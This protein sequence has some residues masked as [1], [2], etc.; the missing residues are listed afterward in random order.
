MQISNIIWPLSKVFAVLLSGFAALWVI[1]KTRASLEMRQGPGPL[2]LFANLLKLVQKGTST[3]NTQSRLFGLCLIAALAGIVYLSAFLTDLD[4]FTTIYI[5]VSIRFF[6]ILAA[7]VQAA[8]FGA[9]GASRE[10]T[11][12][13][14][15]EPALI[16]SLVALSLSVGSIDMHAIIFSSGPTSVAAGIALYLVALVDLSRMPIDD[17]STHLELTM[18]HESMIIECSGRNLAMAE[19]TYAIR[20]GLLFCLI[21]VLF[22][23][24]LCL[25]CFKSAGTF[26]FAI[27]VVAFFILLC[28]T[29]GMIEALWIKMDWRKNPHFIA[30]ALTMS[31]IAILSVLGGH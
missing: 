13:I 20:T 28:L 2:Q 14:L 9:F 26:A 7:L 8:P 17:P 18:V 15:C 31:F 10:L 19:S 16:L 1:R 22:A 12:S 5:L 27:I 21:S 4:I 29:T 24:A 11:L 3:A 23:N 25:Y 30:Y 6:A